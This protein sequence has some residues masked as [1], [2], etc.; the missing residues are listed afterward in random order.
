MTASDPPGDDFL[1]SSRRNV[2]RETAV[3]WILRAAGITSVLISVGILFSLFGRA[4]NFLAGLP[5]L[6]LL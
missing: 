4:A 3:R 2:G 6:S 5:S 1:T